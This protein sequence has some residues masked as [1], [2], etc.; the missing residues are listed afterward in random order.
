MQMKLINC[1]FTLSG[2]IAIQLHVAGQ[3]IKNGRDANDCSAVK[4]SYE[5]S[6]MLQP[7]ERLLTVNHLPIM[8]P[9]ILCHFIY[10][11]SLGF[12]YHTNQHVRDPYKKKKNVL[13]GDKIIHHSRFYRFYERKYYEEVN[14]PKNVKPFFIEDT[15]RGLAWQYFDQTK[16]ILG[17]TCYL[18]ISVN[19]KNDSTLAWFTSDLPFKQNMKD[20]YGLPGV[21]L[22]VYDQR[23]NVYYEAKKI[24][25]TDKLIV[26]PEGIKTVTREEFYKMK[27]SSL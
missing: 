15:I 13:V 1:L 22:M 25:Y 11:D 23:W 12:F 16:N 7:N 9:L 6:R 20:I 14:Y 5:K 2:L 3:S 10:N 19:E 8:E 21:A 4:I 24:E 27:K 18:A 26:Y 17:K